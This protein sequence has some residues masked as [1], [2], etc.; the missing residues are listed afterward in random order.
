MRSVLVAVFTL[1]LLP[2]TALGADPPPG[3]AISDSR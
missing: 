3:A 2:A 1:A